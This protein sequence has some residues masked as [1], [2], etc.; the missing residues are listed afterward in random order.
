MILV[1]L[2][3]VLAAAMVSIEGFLVATINVKILKI[4][5]D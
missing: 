2:E 3:E 1:I 5:K 4:L